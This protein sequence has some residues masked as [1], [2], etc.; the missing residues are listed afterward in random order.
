MNEPSSPWMLKGN[1]PPLHEAATPRS[2]TWQH[3]TRFHSHKSI[4]TASL[5]RPLGLA[6]VAF[7]RKMMCWLLFF[8]R[9]TCFATPKKFQARMATRKICANESNEMAAALRNKISASLKRKHLAFIYSRTINQI[10][11]REKELRSKKYQVQV[12]CREQQ[13]QAAAST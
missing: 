12:D 13:L 2:A 7:A 1:R 5:K 6:S 4:T 8:C 9:L 3:D 11:E 10:R